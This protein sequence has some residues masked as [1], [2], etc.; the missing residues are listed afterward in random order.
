MH[1]PK[2]KRASYEDVLRAPDTMVAEVVEGDLH[3]TPRP[4]RAH[5]RAEIRLATL[6]EGPF[7]MGRGGP[8]GWVNVIRRRS[9]RS[10]LKPPNEL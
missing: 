7:G 4:G 10:G 9:G 6:I 1:E 8:G 2:R 5:G 3:L